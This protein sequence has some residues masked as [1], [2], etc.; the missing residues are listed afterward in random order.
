LSPNERTAAW[1]RG[2]RDQWE[3]E[4]DA[5]ASR[6][7]IPVPRLSELEAGQDRPTALEITQLAWAIAQ[8]TDKPIIR[9]DRFRRALRERAGYPTR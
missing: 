3:I 8:W 4:L 7:S 1:I 6:A 9:E 5:L 2:Q